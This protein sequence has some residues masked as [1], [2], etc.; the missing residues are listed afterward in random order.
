ML[1][2]RI[3]NDD[4]N[5]FGG[6]KAVIRE[7]L[8]IARASECFVGRSQIHPFVQTEINV[9]TFT[10]I[11]LSLAHMLQVAGLVPA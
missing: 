5:Q 9:P 1:S 11:D 10:P 8:D 3:V 4:H 6:I 7:N 2:S